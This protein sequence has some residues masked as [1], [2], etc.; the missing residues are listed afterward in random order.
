[1]RR[2]LLPLCVGLGTLLLLGLGTWQMQRL[3]WKENLI[4][5]RDAGLTVAPTPLPSQL[6]DPTAFEFRRVTL[7]GVFRHD[8]EMLY[9]AKAR[10]SVIG[11]QILTPL[12]REDGSAVLVD[13]G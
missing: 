9:G 6:T 12:I 8:L 3:A 13:R 10:Q 2:M 11:Q 7:T 1:M 5:Q 4:A